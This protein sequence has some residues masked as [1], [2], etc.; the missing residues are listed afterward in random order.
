MIV[1]RS[2]VIGNVNSLSLVFYS[3][4]WILCMCSDSCNSQ[5]LNV[6]WFMRINLIVDNIYVLFG[7]QVF[8]Q[9]VGIFMGTNCVSLLK[10]IFLY[11]YEA[12]FVQK[13]LRD[14]TKNLPCLS[15][16]HLDISMTSYQS[17][18]IIFTIM[19]T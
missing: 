7:D 12:E 13:L 4:Y 9:S 8:Q 3:G 19:S 17:L 10:N 1:I 11:L 2:A 15:T 14:N 16:I 18:I 5:Y 6:F